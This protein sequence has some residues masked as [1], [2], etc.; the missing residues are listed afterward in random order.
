MGF[1]KGPLIC[2]TFCMLQ[3]TLCGQYYMAQIPDPHPGIPPSWHIFSVSPLTCLLQHRKGCI[4]SKTP[5]MCSIYL[6]SEV[7]PSYLCLRSGPVA[8][9]VS[10]SVEFSLF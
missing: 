10:H 1:T 5:N 6:F 8:F 3:I 4:R 2:G 7:F 9:P